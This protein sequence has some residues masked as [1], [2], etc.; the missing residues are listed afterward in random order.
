MY[1]NGKMRPVET[2]LK[3]G[4]GRM[5]EGL[6]LRYTVSTKSQCALITTI[7]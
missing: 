5:L 6:N 2:I 3:M 7:M 4:G 1:E